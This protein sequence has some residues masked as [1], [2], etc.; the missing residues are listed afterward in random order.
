[1]NFGDAEVAIEIFSRYACGAPD[2]HDIREPL[3]GHFEFAHEKCWVSMY[4][5]TSLPDLTDEER[6]QL[7]KAGWFIDEEN[8]AWCHF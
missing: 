3:T 4:R 7:D 5:T 6:E 8:D 2:P 1:M